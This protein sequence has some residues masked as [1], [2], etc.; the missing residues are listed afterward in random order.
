MSSEYRPVFSTELGRLCPECAQAVASCKCKQ[1]AKEIA[2]GDG[3]VRL[4]RETKGRKGKGVTLITGLPMAEPELKALAQDLKKRCSCGGTVS[5]GVIEIQGDQ[6]EVLKIELEKRGF[7]V[8][9]AG[10]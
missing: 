1:K 10:G 4:A 2:V 3:I 7:K 9:L 5:E 6:R 8:K